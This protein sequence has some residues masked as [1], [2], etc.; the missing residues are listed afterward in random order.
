MYVQ[1]K[2]KATLAT[3][4]RLLT[5]TLSACNIIIIYIYI[6][7]KTPEVLDRERE[8]G[9]TVAPRLPCSADCSFNKIVK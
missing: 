5:D 9:K 3:S 6:A 1:S 4:R 7:V 8:F 2:E